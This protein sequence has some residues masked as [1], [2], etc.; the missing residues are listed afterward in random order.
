MQTGDL[1]ER[2]LE[3]KLRGWIYEAKVDVLGLWQL[4]RSARRDW[5]AATPSDVKNLVLSFVS[6]LLDRG[7]QAVNVS[8]L[9][10]WPNQDPESVIQRISSEW[11]SLGREPDVPD[12]V[13]FKMRPNS[14]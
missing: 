9:Q 1:I 11:D 12:I 6:K 7:L 10:P 13:W 14:S 3:E 2:R 8:D 4:C 5:G